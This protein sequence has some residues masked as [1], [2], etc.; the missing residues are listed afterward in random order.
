MSRAAA[1]FIVSAH[2]EHTLVHINLSVLLSMAMIQTYP[3]A[4]SSTISTAH[5]GGAKPPWYVRCTDVSTQVAISCTTL[6][7]LREVPLLVFIFC[8]QETQR[9]HA[10]SHG[11]G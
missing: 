5:T 7:I 1:V 10:T 2:W 6:D 8:F 11:T 4:V 3:L 9:Q